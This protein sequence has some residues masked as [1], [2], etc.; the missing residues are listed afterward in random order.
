MLRNSTARAC[1]MTALA[2]A[3]SMTMVLP[4][5]LASNVVT[6]AW[7]IK[8]GPVN[9]KGVKATINTVGAYYA[10][11]TGQVSYSLTVNF[12]SGDWV[13]F[14]YIRGW[15][16]PSPHGGLNL[17]SAPTVYVEEGSGTVSV[18]TMFNTLLI[19]STHTYDIHW[20]GTSGSLNVWT[21]Y[22]DGVAVYASNQGSSDAN[23]LNVQVQ[24]ESKDTADSCSAHV[25]FQSLQYGVRVA[26]PHAPP[27]FN[28][29]SWNGYSDNG[30]NGD[31]RAVY[32][33]NSLECWLL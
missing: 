16:Y 18:V 11:N 24:G 20:T 3:V 21:C 4:A 27:S 22:L 17:A 23:A 7:E 10:P 9:M 12:I 25:W 19:P 33:S 29:Y 28:W 8:S 32:G 13:Q 1:V 5:V 30:V 14:G 2:I 26:R 31:W 6:W 15:Y